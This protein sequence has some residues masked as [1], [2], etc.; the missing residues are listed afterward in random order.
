MGKDNYTTD[1]FTTVSTKAIINTN[2]RNF[3]ADIPG[4]KEPESPTRG[5]NK[6]WAKWG[7]DDNFPKNVMDDLSK[8]TVALRALTRRAEVH[9][10]NGLIYFKEK[11][12]G[13]KLEIEPQKIAEID[14][15]LEANEFGTQKFAHILDL[16]VFYNGASSLIF[17]DQK[18]KV[19]GYKYHKMSQ[20][21]RELQNPRTKRIEN[22]YISADEQFGQRVDKILKIPTYNPLKPNRSPSCSILSAYPS[23]YNTYHY[24]ISAWN[25]IRENGWITI[26][27]MV[28][29]LKAAIFKNQATIKY[30]VKVPTTYWNYRFKDWETLGD[31]ERRGRI[32]DWK[33]EL[34]D[35]LTD[36]ENSGKSFV[37]FY[38]VDDFGKAMPG[39]EIEAI[40]NKMKNDAFLPDTGASNLEVLFA[41]GL[42]PS[43][44]GVSPDGSAEGSGSSVREHLTALQ[45]SMKP[46]RDIS[47]RDLYIIKKINK[48][49]AE[50]KFGYK[51]I[52]QS[53]T[54]DKNPTGKTLTTQ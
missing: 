53:A 27:P 23:P 50:I 31:E 49:D 32:D 21:R 51:D 47:L 15:F 16:E 13:T 10:G 17:D 20:C 11:V 5:E 29:A 46:Y 34:D 33:V 24:E 35:F 44:I 54:L 52:D 45:G 38:D 40:D 41:I 4:S 37:S 19:I 30:H 36:V 48:W 22:L 3:G 2:V 18:E 8:N 43:L 9:Y 14:D 6:E 42:S 26:G 1:V 7:T 25:S 39:F 28:A 12:N